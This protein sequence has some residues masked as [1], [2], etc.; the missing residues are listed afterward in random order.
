[1]FAFIIGSA[2]GIELQTIEAKDSQRDFNSL[3]QSPHLIPG[4]HQIL[5]KEID[6]QVLKV[7]V[8]ALAGTHVKLLELSKEGIFRIKCVQDS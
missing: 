1:M 5:F 6:C 8:S 3:D 4:N 2:I 7:F